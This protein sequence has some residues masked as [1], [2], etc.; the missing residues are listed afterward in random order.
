MRR[1]SGRQIQLVIMTG[2]IALNRFRAWP[3]MAFNRL[4]RLLLVLLP[5]PGMVS[6]VQ[7]YSHYS[8][9]QARMLPFPSCPRCPGLWKAHGILT[10]VKRI[11]EMSGNAR[12]SGLCATYCCGD[13]ID[14]HNAML[15]HIAGGDGFLAALEDG[16]L[17]LYDLDLPPLHFVWGDRVAQRCNGVRTSIN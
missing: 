1:T 5:R 9:G 2:V 8:G 17:S 12:C 3:C 13:Y 4:S 6:D 15:L 14:C 11:I 16:S 10:R 7:W